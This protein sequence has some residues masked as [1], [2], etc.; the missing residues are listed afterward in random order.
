MPLFDLNEKR[1]ERKNSSNN[2][3]PIVISNEEDDLK[4]KKNGSKQNMTHV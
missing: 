2:K 4:I 1:Y 3:I